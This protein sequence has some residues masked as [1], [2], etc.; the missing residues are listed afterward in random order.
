MARNLKY[1]S[2]TDVEVKNVS[3]SASLVSEGGQHVT[4][5]DGGANSLHVKDVRTD[6]LLSLILLELRKM[7]LHLSEIT[8]EDISAD[9]IV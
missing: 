2:V 9:E 6:E 4:I 1:N 3:L 5:S 7:S 8:N